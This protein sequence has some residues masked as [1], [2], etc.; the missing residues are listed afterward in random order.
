MFPLLQS[1][2]STSRNIR[3]LDSKMYKTSKVFEVQGKKTGFTQTYV[4]FPPSLTFKTYYGLDFCKSW[5]ISL[6]Y[7]FYELSYIIV[8]SSRWKSI[9]KLKTM[10]D[11][12]KANQ[13]ESSRLKNMKLK[14]DRRM[15]RCILTN[16][17]K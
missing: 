15:N 1:T 6:F 17:F 2:A 4:F 10:K 13:K 12:E 5:T 16:N 3:N 7:L 11:I 9:K 14:I 8:K